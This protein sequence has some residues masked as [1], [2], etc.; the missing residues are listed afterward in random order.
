MIWLCLDLPLSH[1]EGALVTS[2][3][4]AVPA[5]LI[6]G[7]LWLVARHIVKSDRV[8]MELLCGAPGVQLHLGVFGPGPATSSASPMAL[9]LGIDCDLFAH[10]SIRLEGRKCINRCQK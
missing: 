10:S 8:D 2:E 3:G 5:L 1:F 6:L 7:I 9:S 4:S